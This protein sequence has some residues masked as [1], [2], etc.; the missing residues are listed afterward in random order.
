MIIYVLYIFSNEVIGNPR[1][2]FCD[3][4][5]AFVPLLTL[6]EHKSYIPPPHRTHYRRHTPHTAQ[7]V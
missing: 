3:S 2:S 1:L 7:Y 4:C 5:L 6:T